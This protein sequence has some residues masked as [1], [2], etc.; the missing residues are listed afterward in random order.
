MIPFI[1]SGQAFP[2]LAA[3]RDDMGGLLAIGGELGPERL[4]AAYRQGIFPWGTL[5]GL[6]LWY[7]PDPRMVLAP[8]D[9]RLHRS[10]RR[11]LRTGRYR[12]CMDR[13]FP[14]VIAACAATPRPGQDGTWITTDMQEA[15]IRLHELGWAHSVETWDGDTLVGGLYGLAIGRAFFG[16]S[17]F[18]HRSDASK[19]AFAHLC[20]R[21][22]ELEFTLIDCQMHTSHLAS[23]GAAPIPRASFLERLQAATTP[24][25]PRVLASGEL[26]YDW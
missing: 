4:V 14:A 19:I 10:L 2:P 3:I 11:T 13:N 15:Y 22:A 12:V 8:Q 26:R 17:M 21:L 23:L 1:Q 9:F 5:E 18:S 6:P 20:R 7:N 16:E 24:T 25:V